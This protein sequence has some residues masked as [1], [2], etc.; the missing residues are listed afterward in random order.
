MSIENLNELEGNREIK[1]SEYIQIE[2]DSLN[3]SDELQPVAHSLFQVS[4]LQ[5]EEIQNEDLKVGQFTD[6]VFQWFLDTVDSLSVYKEEF[7]GYPL[8]QTALH[9]TELCQDLFSLRI[10]HEDLAKQ[11]LTL[12]GLSISFVN[13]SKTYLKEGHLMDDLICVGQH[14]VH[15]LKEQILQP[16]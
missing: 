10:E 9:I 12:I 16:R 8:F 14:I 1:E 4:H 13:Q 5:F 15:R 2:V 3:L 6:R 7:K 11:L